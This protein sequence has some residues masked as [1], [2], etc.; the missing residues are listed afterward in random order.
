MFNH[1]TNYFICLES[2]FYLLPYLKFSFKSVNF[3]N[4]YARDVYLQWY[5]FYF[6]VLFFFCIFSAVLYCVYFIINAALCKLK[7]GNGIEWKSHCSNGTFSDVLFTLLL[8]KNV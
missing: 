3:S 5:C 6:Y 2:A 4:S 1:N 7:I 8:A